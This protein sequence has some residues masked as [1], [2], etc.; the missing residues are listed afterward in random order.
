MTGVL[1]R[2]GNLDIGIAQKEDTGRRQPPTK[3]GE[4][5]EKKSTLPI[6]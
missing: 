4:R 2:R 3:Q 1:I 5:P 6:P